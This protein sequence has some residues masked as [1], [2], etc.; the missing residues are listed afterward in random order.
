MAGNCIGILLPVSAFALIGFEHSV[1]ATF[2]L[3]TGLL[4][5]MAAT[6]RDLWKVVLLQNM[7]SVTLGHALAGF[8]LVG[9]GF[10]WQFGK[11]GKE[12]Q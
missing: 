6:T 2:L 9:G 8:L 10:S 5:M 12:K 1:A 3:P 7:F 11:L 4:S